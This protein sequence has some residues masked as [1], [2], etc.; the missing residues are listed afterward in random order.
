MGASF[1]CHRFLT[2]SVACVILATVRLLLHNGDERM[3]RPI[4]VKYANK[5]DGTIFVRTSSPVIGAVKEVNT[6]D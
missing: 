1:Y 4:K 5:D 2:D 3:T 6:N